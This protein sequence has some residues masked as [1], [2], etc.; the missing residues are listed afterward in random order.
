MTTDDEFT[1]PTEQAMAQATQRI[2]PRGVAEPADDTPQVLDGF[3]S[4]I[5][6]QLPRT[7]YHVGID[8]GLLIL[9]VAV[10][11]TMLL[12]GLYKYGLF[13]GIGMDAM[14]EALEGA[15]FTSQTWA[16]AW[17]LVLTEVASGGM[18]ILGMLTPA[19]AAAALGVTATATYLAREVGYYPDMLES[20]GL[21]PGYQLPLLVAAGAM[22]LLFTGPGRIAVDAPTPWRRKPLPFGLVGVAA[23]AAASVAVLALFT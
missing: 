10:G 1:R 16:L 15:G 7:R 21:I 8:L 20:G 13:D 3:E 11:G 6:E 14:P 22:A 9:R 2:D 17:L 5:E 18:L 12:S 4:A 19:A 23:A